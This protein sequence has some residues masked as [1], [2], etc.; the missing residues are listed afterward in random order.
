M[1]FLAGFLLIAALA[2]LGAIDFAARRLLNAVF[3]AF[4]ALFLLFAL[5]IGN[6]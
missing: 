6:L 4:T 5:L 3:E 2:T 1:T